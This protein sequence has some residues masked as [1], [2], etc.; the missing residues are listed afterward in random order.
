MR[1]SVW[2]V[3]VMK[4]GLSGLLLGGGTGCAAFDL[5]AA[6]AIQENTPMQ[7]VVRRADA[8]RATVANVE[9][10]LGN[11]PVDE[12]SKW[13]PKLAVKKSDAEPILKDVSNDPE[14]ASLKGDK[15]RVVP[16]E[17]WAV[18]LSKVCSTEKK[19]PSLYATISDEVH[20]Q[21]VDVA[22]Q[23]K[24]VAKLKRKIAAE[25]DAIDDKEK[26]DEKSD[27]EEKKKDLEGKLDD[28]EKEYKPKVEAFKKKLGEDTGKASSDV[29]KQ[30]AAA[31]VVLRRAIAD[32]KIANTAALIGYPKAAPGLKDEVKTIVKRIAADTIEL[33]IGTRPNLEKL[34]PEVKLSPVSVTIAGL[35]PSDLGKLK[36]EEA[37]KDI[38]NRSKDYVVHV[39]TL[40]P[41]IA[42]TAEMLAFQQDMLEEAQ[43]GVGEGTAGEDFGDLQVTASMTPGKGSE[44]RQPVPMEACVEKKD[45]KADADKG[46]KGKG[47]KGGKG[48][49]G[50]GDKGKGDKGKAA[51]P[52][53]KK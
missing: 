38:A 40:L 47:G 23:A 44:K 33:N 45:D 13:V 32:A 6:W 35:S 25:Q 16:A 24:K 17:A 26:A 14:F 46:D 48:D 7:A 43:K 39:V 49:K 18:L 29:K 11:T 15:L 50:K 12:D 30:L 52:P 28:L 1:R 42:E 53:K 41:Y 5:K 31:I 27:H 19:S 3:L 37:V 9:R 20:T 4:L 22:S 10:L 36:L 34:T 21:Y 2:P 8:A 51:P